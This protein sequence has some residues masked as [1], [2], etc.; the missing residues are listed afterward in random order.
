MEAAIPAVKERGYRKKMNKKT[1]NAWFASNW[2]AILSCV[3]SFMAFLIVASFTV[4]RE[5]AK[6]TTQVDTFD[7]KIE[8]LA[9]DIATIKEQN[10]VF[11]ERLD[12]FNSDI[13]DIQNDLSILSG[14]DPR[15]SRLSMSDTYKAS[16]IR[17]VGTLDSFVLTNASLQYSS[18]VAYDSDNNP[19]TVED[20]AQKKL[21]LP[22][23]EDG[24]ECFFY[25]QLDKDGNW[26]G[27][28]SINIYEGQKLT[29]VTEAVYD[30]GNLLT[31]Q[32]AFPSHGDKGALWFF[33]NRKME[34]GFSSGETWD[35]SYSH[36]FVQEFSYDSV[37][38]E[39]L[40]TIEDLWS[41]A[42]EN[43]YLEGYYNGRTSGGRFNDTSG[44][45]Y[46][47]KY[48][49]D[50]T[51]RTLY[52]GMF[53]KGVFEDKTCNAWMIGRNDTAS[54]Y[55]YYHDNTF[56]NGVSDIPPGSPKAKFYWELDI[57][58][59]RINELLGDFILEK[60]I[61]APLTGLV[62]DTEEVSGTI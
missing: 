19:L 2:K 60:N 36:D 6:I 26:D 14:R 23:R 13:K 17:C 11:N 46:M 22:Y 4:G 9:K 61:S 5:Y 38:P 8:S 32:Q 55:S 43:G 25:G 49:E 24:K 35:F 39:D 30:S 45:A 27:E 21:L 29:L 37:K 16:V 59:E 1:I 10:A 20:V 3:V 51:V 40:L 7:G 41:K 12:S 33:S 62:L 15:L 34:D 47:I 28:C 53:K 18:V 44:E 58:Q 57:D 52:S 54:K 48:F 56:T 31:F 50:G 42:E